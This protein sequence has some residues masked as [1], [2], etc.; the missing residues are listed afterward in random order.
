VLDP[1]QARRRI[2]ARA[3]LAHFLYRT[4]DIVFL[5]CYERER[6]AR[7]TTVTEV[8]AR[9]QTIYS[10][11]YPQDYPALYIEPWARKH[12]LN[13]ANLFAILSGLRKPLPRWL[14]L[15]CS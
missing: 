11:S 15:A 14:D 2:P 13:A 4:Q 9:V 3:D 10:E 1:K 12:E 8:N 6:G 5:A 7:A